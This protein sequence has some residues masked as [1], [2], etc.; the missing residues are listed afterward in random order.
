[1]MRMDEC[2]MMPSDGAYKNLPPELRHL[3]QQ[4][5]PCP[6]RLLVHYSHSTIQSGS[7]ANWKLALPFSSWFC[8]CNPQLFCHFQSFES[9]FQ[10][11]LEETHY[12]DDRHYK[13]IVKMMTGN[14]EEEEM[15]VGVFTV[16]TDL[17]LPSLNHKT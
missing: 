5:K 14:K 9:A 12:R 8:L 11:C 4:T 15:P 17:D 6:P 7:E 16:I 10:T 1:M 13:G 3:E 2:H